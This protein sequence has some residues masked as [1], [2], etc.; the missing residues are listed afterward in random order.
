MRYRRDFRSLAT[1]F[2]MLALL[3]A[4]RRAELSLRYV[5]WATRYLKIPTRDSFASDNRRCPRRVV[6]ALSSL[7]VFNDDKTRRYAAPSIHADVLIHV[8]PSS[9]G[10]RPPSKIDRIEDLK[11]PYLRARKTSIG[12]S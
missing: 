2:A 7:S 8:L 6:N 12:S 4:S 10:P 5:A 3:L 9:S 11:D 1:C